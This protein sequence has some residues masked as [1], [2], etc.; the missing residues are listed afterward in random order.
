MTVPGISMRI[1]WTPTANRKRRHV[2]DLD[3]FSEQE[4]LDVLDSAVSMKE[5]L[6]RSVPQV[7]IL[8][9]RTVVNVFYEES[10]RTRMSFELAARTL[11]ASTMSMTAKGSSVEKGES[12][13]DTIRTIQALGA[14]IIVIRHGESGAPYLAAQHFRGSIINAGDG[15]H[16]HPSQALLDLFTIREKLGIL[17]D[18]HVV[19][20]GDILHSRV[21]RSN[22]WGML[23]CGMR[24][25]LCG[26]ST[27]I[28]SAQMWQSTF[29][30]LNISYQLD[31]LLPHT[32]VLMGLRLQKE[33][34][35][36]G[37][38]PALREYST[39]FGIDGERLTKL[40]AHAIVMHPGPMNEGVEIMPEAA[41]SPRSV[42]ETQVT[43]GVA[44]RMALLY[45]LSGE[46]GNS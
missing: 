14:D 32:D 24:V 20:T 44:V 21:A 25:T 41:D 11:S 40:P 19:I 1:P 10:T 4:I 37:L 27:L 18:A 8:R 12:L 29:P 43:N 30:T 35:Q 15:R 45:Q 23:R 9:G 17:K 2:L 22:I 5:I 26:P 34:M 3:D 46:Q 33:R 13:I 39:Y 6:G 42:I 36:A 28:G 38:L 7:P 16:A 31:E